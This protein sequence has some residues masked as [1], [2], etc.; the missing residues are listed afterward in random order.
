MAKT[1][2]KPAMRTPIAAYTEVTIVKTGTVA[3]HE[4][5]RG[6]KYSVDVSTLKA[7]QDQEMINV[8]SAG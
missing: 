7:M 1:P 6:R 3:G 5:R 4:F 2:Q 8:V